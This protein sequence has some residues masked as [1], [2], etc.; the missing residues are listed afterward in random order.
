[1]RIIVKLDGLSGLVFSNE[2]LADPDD[3]YTRAIKVLTAK[4]AQKTDV[5]NAEIAKLEWFGGLYH[6][7]GFGVYLPTWNLIRCFEQ[8]GKITK[9]GTAVIRALS[10]VSDKVPVLH[11]GPSEPSK[12]WERPEFRLR[13]MVGIKGSR[14]PRMRPIFRRWGIEFEAEFMDD[15]LNMSDFVRIVEQAGRS[16][17]LG[18]A[19]KLGYGR[20]K[21][22]VIR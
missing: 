14:V 19:R 12:L 21:A 8:A 18:S 20:F 17:G 7:A 4:G 13:K 11:D 5:D 1:M 16:E 2:R 9:K 15:V 3:E 10:P 22:E 6:E